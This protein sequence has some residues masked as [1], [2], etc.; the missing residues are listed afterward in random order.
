MKKSTIN[1]LILTIT[2]LFVAS[3]SADGKDLLI[4]IVPDVK[5]TV[6]GSG[7]IL[8]IL[9]DVVVST[10]SY[11]KTKNILVFFSVFAVMLYF[12]YVMGVI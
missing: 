6:S 10:I 5:A 12:T 9:G 4:G 1:L 2:M 8:I 11:V 3:A 7:K